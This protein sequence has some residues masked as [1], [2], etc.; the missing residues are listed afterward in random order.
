MKTGRPSSYKPEYCENLISHF[1]IDP[2]I[3]KDITI[4]YKDGTTCE[5]SVPE[6]SP[7]PY[8]S[9]WQK[10]IG[11]SN[12]TM[13][14]WTKV[15][16]EFLDAYKRAKQLQEEFLMETALK[17]VHNSTFTIFAM[18]NIC[19]W[20]DEQHIKGDGFNQI[21]NIVRSDGSKVE[22]VSGRV[23]VQRSTLSSN[24]V[25]LG[26][27]KKSLRDSKSVEVVRAIPEQSSP[28]LP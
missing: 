2:I 24:G 18:K 27:G 21:I 12:Q 3:Y 11:I 10:K 5:K 8:F 26:N 16:V 6:A 14:D 23:R 4:T 9:E 1:D 17:G 15:H 22:E 20:R 19:G 25:S 28:N 7:T 13:H